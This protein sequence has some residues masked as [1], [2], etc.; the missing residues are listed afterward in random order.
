MT[1]IAGVALSNPDRV[2][3]PDQG[4]TKRELAQYYEAM[5]PL[6]L[7]YL[8]RRPFSLVRCPSGR[9]K[10]CFYQKHWTGRLPAGV[11]TV[12]IRETRGDLREY[13][14]VDSAKGLV[15]LVQHGVLEFHV[16]G[17]RIDRLEL[18]D[19]MV[20]DLD[21]APGVAWDRVRQAAREMR[22]LLGELGLESWIKT[23]GGKG[24]HVV[25][26]IARRWDW[27]AVS[28]FARTVA[29]GMAEESPDR[30]LARASKAE[31]KGRIFVDWLR[32]T[33]GATSIAAWS[34]RARAGAPVSLPV[35]WDDL[36][37]IESADQYTI[38]SVPALLGR[39]RKD[40]WQSMIGVHQ[41]LPR[42]PRI[43]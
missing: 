43:A 1:T 4:I 24:L 30:Y 5:A 6:I 2:L 25:V 13:T 12:E 10:A 23:T 37:T 16:W 31:R 39:R 18:P 28:G 32:N 36:D 26:P 20:F 35:S 33:R 14:W 29:Y 40:P 21:P 8:A 11:R 3:Y 38:R 7:P 19:R 42:L 9:Q 41:R 27:K 17:S 15:G 22:I 34:T